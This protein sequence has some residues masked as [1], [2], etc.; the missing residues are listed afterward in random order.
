MNTEILKS[1]F[2]SLSKKNNISFE[3]F[4]FFMKILL[5]GID[6]SNAVVEE[7]FSGSFDENSNSGSGHTILRVTLNNNVFIFCSYYNYLEKVKSKMPVRYYFF[8]RLNGKPVNYELEDGV[9]IHKLSAMVSKRLDIKELMPKPNFD[10]VDQANVLN[11]LLEIAQTFPCKSK[12]DK[13]AEARVENLLLSFDMDSAEIKY[14]HEGLGDENSVKIPDK[15]DPVCIIMKVNDAT[16]KFKLISYEGQ[17]HADDYIFY[18]VAVND[19]DC[20]IRVNE[21][22]YL[23]MAKRIDGED[24]NLEKINE[25]AISVLQS[26]F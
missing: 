5:N 1:K 13:S 12:E 25:E 16:L 20:F 23:M 22:F 6:F 11:T 17:E 19:K 9:L 8:E 14:A 26:V 18:L 3:E 7:G 4:E 10:A 15:S 24:G 21:V 2:D